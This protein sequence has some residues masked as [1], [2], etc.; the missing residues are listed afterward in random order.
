MLPPHNFAARFM[1]AVATLT[2]N[3]FVELNK[4]L[5]TEKFVVI[6]YYIW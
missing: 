5:A 1:V 6:N 3:E 4:S 2:K